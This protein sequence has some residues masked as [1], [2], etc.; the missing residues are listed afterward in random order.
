M[1]GGIEGFYQVDEKGMG[2]QIV[3]AAKL[4][5]GAEGV[6]AVLASTSRLGAELRFDAFVFNN[7]KETLV[8]DGAVDTGEGILK[9]YAMPIGRTRGVFSTFGD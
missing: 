5:G 4:E 7:V 9:A 2:R 6:K 3:R 1:V 8:K